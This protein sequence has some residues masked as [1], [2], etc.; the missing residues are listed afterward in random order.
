MPVPELIVRPVFHKGLAGVV[1]AVRGIDTVAVVE[2]EV[3]IV[4]DVQTVDVLRI[5][6]ACI[7]SPETRDV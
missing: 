6:P 3:V 5:G 1:A 4:P 7:R 2:P